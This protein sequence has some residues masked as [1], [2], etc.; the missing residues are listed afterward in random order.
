MS[1]RFGANVHV[2][3]ARY[4]DIWAR[5]TGVIPTE[6]GGVRFGFNAWG[7]D[8][9][10]Y[11][12]WSDDLTVPVQMAEIAGIPLAGSPLVAEGGNLT[13]DGAGTLIA[14]RPCIVNKNRNPGIGAEEAEAEL[15]RALG[16]R[17]VIW[18]DE[19]LVYDETGG[20]V[21]NLCAFVARKTVMLAWTDDEKNVQYGPVHRAAEVLGAARDADGDPLTIIKVPL[22]AVS[23]RT[24][25]DC[26]DLETTHAS[27]NRLLGEPMQA[28]YINFVF[29][30]GGVIVPVFGDACDAAALEIFRRFFKDREV[31]PFAAR[32]IILGGG[33]LHCITKN[34]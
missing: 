11:N 33:G 28:S 10:L 8:E 26:E 2:F 12:D 5:D 14:V 1:E 27:K 20:H 19:G 24:E 6:R 7:G 31:V 16:A 18:L 3:P 34:L 29:V 23:Y 13:S 30:N 17:K 15:G 22:P 4:N 32:E 9:G 25:E 21:D